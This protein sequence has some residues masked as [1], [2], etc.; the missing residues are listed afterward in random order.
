MINVVWHTQKSYK[1]HHRQH[2]FISKRCGW[3]WKRF[4]GNISLCEEVR[5]LDEQGPISI[6]DIE[7]EDLND[8]NVCLVCLKK[9]KKISKKK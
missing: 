8:R 7:S 3:F 2:G 1:R 6:N 5:I 4:D 9:F